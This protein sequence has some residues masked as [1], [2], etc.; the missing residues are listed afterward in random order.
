MVTRLSRRRQIDEVVQCIEM[1]CEFLRL[2]VAGK[3]LCELFH[4]ERSGQVDVQRVEELPDGVRIV[5]SA[6]AQELVKI[7]AAVPVGIKL[8]ERGVPG[9]GLLLVLLVAVAMVVVVKA[10]VL[11]PKEVAGRA[12]ATGSARLVGTRIT[13]RAP[14]ATCVVARRRGPLLVAMTAG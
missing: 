14:S 13:P 12:T 5:A 10:A 3:R 6:H 4:L 9:G 8:A 2:G 11:P 1:L 7:E